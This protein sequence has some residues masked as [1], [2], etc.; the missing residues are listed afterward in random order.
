MISS[1]DV[2][3]DEVLDFVRAFPIKELDEALEPWLRA[4]AGKEESS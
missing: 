4:R 1:D 3:S 2:S